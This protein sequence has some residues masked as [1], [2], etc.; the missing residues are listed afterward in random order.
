MSQPLNFF[1]SRS[2]QGFIPA[3]A[4]F[5]SCV[6]IFD[7]I[8]WL[9]W[10]GDQGRFFDLMSFTVGFPSVLLALALAAASTWS[11]AGKV[12]FSQA[13]GWAMRLMP[14]A[15]LVPFIDFIRLTG[16][17]VPGIVPYLNGWGI[18]QAIATAG[19]FPWNSSLNLGIRFGLVAATFGTA[20]ITWHISKSWWKAVLSGVWVS[21][22]G[23]ASML[24]VSLAIFLNTSGSNA[25]WSA[26]SV[27]MIRRSSTILG[28]GYWWEAMYDR[29]PTAIDNQIDIATRLFSAVGA[30][31]VVILFL[32][33][34]FLAAKTRRRLLRYAFGTWG[35]VLFVSAF[36]VGIACG[37]KHLSL[38]QSA[39]FVPAYVFFLYLI[40]ALRLSSV[41][42]RDMTNLE[43][44]E[45]LG[46]HQPILDGSLTLEEA[47]TISG[48][49][50]V[51]A[52]IAG[53]VLGWPVL[54]MVLGYLGCARLTRD[55]FWTA[56]PQVSTIFRAVG[57]SAL[58]GAG[59]LFV[60]QDI[61][62]SSSLLLSFGAAAAIRLLIEWF[63]LPKFKGIVDRV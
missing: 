19:I 22:I 47:K 7:L 26:S 24:S 29:F 2:W 9:A 10:H 49:G 52:V 23:V 12:E 34:L 21:V 53:F 16:S 27:E 14:L 39:V 31:H 28:K 63:W 4:S 51:T 37:Y 1:S 57:A 38:G 48:I 20:M 32:T 33:G 55:R 25:A 59:Y 17:G 44:D 50:E 45:R 56:T 6:A 18:V 8:A 43:Q 46:V 58:A 41:F 54:I 60:T 35:F 40:A 62:I 36:I 13:F 61:R 5:A 15:W 11:I 42:R 30:F 3:A